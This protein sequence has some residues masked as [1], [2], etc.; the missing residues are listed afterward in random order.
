MDISI[1][2]AWAGV[3]VGTGTLARLWKGRSWLLWA[4][5]AAAVYAFIADP[6]LQGMTSRPRLSLNRSQLVESGAI[7]LAVFGAASAALALLPPASE[8][9]RRR[10]RRQYRR[11]LPTLAAGEEAKQ[12]PSCVEAVSAKAEVC[13]FCGHKFAAAASR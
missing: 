13:P 1:W 9:R 2:L 3:T 7:A 11:S 5:L 6:P 8:P 4:G 10:H 12:C